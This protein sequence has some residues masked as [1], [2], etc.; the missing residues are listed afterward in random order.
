MSLKRINWQNSSNSLN[1]ARKTQSLDETSLSKQRRFSWS[2]SKLFRRGFSDSAVGLKH[3]QSLDVNIDTAH[4]EIGTNS[5]SPSRRRF[6]RHSKSENAIPEHEEYN[7]HDDEKEWEIS[8][9]C[10]LRPSSNRRQSLKRFFARKLS[11]KESDDIPLSLYRSHSVDTSLPHMVDNLHKEH[12]RLK[13]FYSEGT[14]PFINQPFSSPIWPSELL[15]YKSGDNFIIVLREVVGPVLLVVVR[16]PFT[17]FFSLNIFISV[18]VRNP[19]IL[20]AF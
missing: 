2:V 5:Q 7:Q 15:E 12:G 3:C 17:S 20:Y 1:R 18:M 11:L 4:M 8:K 19:A 9:N 10:L 6:A 14:T 16:I 13:R